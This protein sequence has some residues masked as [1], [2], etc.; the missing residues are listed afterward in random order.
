[1]AEA[2]QFTFGLKEVTAALIKEL[3][4]HEGKWVIAFEFGLGAGLFGMEAS[5]VRPGA[6]VTVQNVQLA[7]H[8]ANIP[9][10]ALV[11]DAAE[12]NP[13]AT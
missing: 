5:E 3:R 1:M 11:V 4:L 12:V 8:P 6:V 2:S 9:A 7:R 10:H 13:P